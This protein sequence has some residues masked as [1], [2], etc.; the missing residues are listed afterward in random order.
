MSV[1]EEL[2]AAKKAWWHAWITDEETGMEAA[3]KL[4]D[5]A[6]AAGAA[7]LEVDDSPILHDTLFK[8]RHFWWQAKLAENQSELA[9]LDAKL[10]ELQAKGA[11]LSADEEERIAAH[12]G[13]PPADAAGEELRALGLPHILPMSGNLEIVAG[14]GNRLNYPTQGVTGWHGGID[15]VDRELRQTMWEGRPAYPV[16]IRA[17]AA[18]SIE[19]HYRDLAAGEGGLGHFAMVYHDDG[20]LSQYA[21]MVPIRGDA[22]SEAVIKGSLS[23]DNKAPMR[24]IAEAVWAEPG[25]YQAVLELVNGVKGTVRQGDIIGFLGSSGKSYGFHLHFAMASS[26]RS[27]VWNDEWTLNPEPLLPGLDLI[28]HGDGD[29]PA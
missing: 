16:P 26:R 12:Y 7:A 15:F 10:S 9:R 11:M 24:T 23:E 19:Y 8:A 20:T 29:A 17:V 13:Q 22:K 3:H 18:G 14:F 27:N 1:K 28:P 2:L 6:R 21:H 4:A 25:K 5:E